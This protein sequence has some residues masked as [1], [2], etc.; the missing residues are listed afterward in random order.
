VT[1]RLI[2]RELVALIAVAV[3]VGAADARG[4]AASGG[5]AASMR[6]GT[7]S[8]ATVRGPG[9]VRPGHRVRIL[10]SGFRPGSRVRIQFGVYPADATLNCCVSYVQPLYGHPGF[11]INGEGRRTIVVVMPRRWA[12]CVA[13]GCPSPG[14]RSYRPG[15]RV[16]VAAV[17]DYDYSDY[18]AR[19]G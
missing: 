13:T 16:S 9:V 12:Q 2:R 17:S 15:Q 5:S 14:W 4:S 10:L 6:A 8:R 18:V 3:L 19:A 11:K 7:A 1:A